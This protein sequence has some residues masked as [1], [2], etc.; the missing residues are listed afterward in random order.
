MFSRDSSLLG[1]AFDG[2]L[3]SA[4]VARRSG[5]RIEVVK[6]CHTRLSLDPIGS[7]PALAGR[8]IRSQLDAAGIHTR[9]CAVAI[10]VGWALTSQVSVPDLSGDDLASFLAL[11]AERDF[12]FPPGDLSI[13]SSMPASDEAPRQAL[14]AALPLSRLRALD[15]VLHA[16]GLRPASI[17]FA[18]TSLARG[19]APA[20]GALVLASENAIDLCIGGATGVSALRALEGPTD[21]GAE[22]FEFD[23]DTLSRELRITLRRMSPSLSENIKQLHIAGQSPLATAL[24]ADLSV[25]GVLPGFEVRRVAT[26]GA[27]TEDNSP[28]YAAAANLL[29]GEAPDFEFLPPKV[30]PLRRFVSSAANR[31]VRWLAP[32]AAAVVLLTGGLFLY[33]QQRLARLES[34][35]ESVRDEIAE[36]ETLQGDIRTYRDWFS[37]D[38]ESLKLTQGLTEAFPEEGSAWAR[39][40]TL[41]ERDQ[42]SCAGSA[43]SND[44]WLAVFGKLNAD[45]RVTDLKVGQV[46]GDTPLQFTFSYHWKDR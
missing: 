41:K 8:E 9:R 25:Q 13:A 45:S 30:S 3:M 31:G 46:S 38:A 43:R 32:A 28:A 15:N 12:P 16:A 19:V 26:S 18:V 39:T 21:R 14:I 7:E 40:V 24:E 33:Q 42:V 11:Q 2:R 10:P 35:W 20:G 29:R 34:R 44:A 37:N 36:L 1:L 23:T 6:H 27:P 4:T 17:T 5:D 22:G